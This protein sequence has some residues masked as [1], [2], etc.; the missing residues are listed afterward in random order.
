MG[1][2]TIEPAAMYLAQE[3]PLLLPLAAG[4]RLMRR[5]HKF[6][7]CGTSFDTSSSTST[8]AVAAVRSHTGDSYTALLGVATPAPDPANRPVR[9]IALCCYNVVLHACFE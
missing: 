1:P 2:F 4:H 5:A 6:L 3:L 8:A 9:G 7:E